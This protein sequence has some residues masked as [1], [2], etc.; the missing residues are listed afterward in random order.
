MLTSTIRGIL[1]QRLLRRLCTRC[2]EEYEPEPALLK[3]LDLPDDT[4]FFQ[5]KGCRA[6]QNSG[7]KGRIGVFE[8]LVPDDEIFRLV[9]QGA[10]NDEIRNYL[11]DQGSF[12]SL[13][14]DG[15]MK[16]SRGFTSLE[17]VLAS[18]PEF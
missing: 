16:A 7:Y 2:R 14:T 4:R 10:S 3:Q 5:A 12:T 9:L 18:T 8:L 1:G 15:L 11:R 17:Q 13:R 6:C